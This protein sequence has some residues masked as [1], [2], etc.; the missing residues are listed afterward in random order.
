MPDI[1]PGD[2]VAA[3]DDV[4]YVATTPSDAPLERIVTK[5]FGFRGRCHLEAISAGLI[6][7]ISGENPFLIPASA[8]DDILH[9]GATIDRGVEPEGLTVLRWRPVQDGDQV[10]TVFRFVDEH[11]RAQFT[12]TMSELRAAH[13][14]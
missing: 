3:W 8:L 10:D 6:V 9:T 11:E 1:Q 2:T 5:P 14:A 4:H 12:V 13:A 7:T